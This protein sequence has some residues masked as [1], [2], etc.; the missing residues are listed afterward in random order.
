MRLKTS[1]VDFEII[2]LSFQ[3]VLRL[4]VLRLKFLD[5]DFRLI[6][7]S[8][9]NVYLLLKLFL[10]LL[11]FSL[12]LLRKLLLCLFDSFLFL[13]FHIWLHCL[14]RVVHNC[15]FSFK[16][17]SLAFQLMSVDLIRF[18][19][20]LKSFHLSILS[21]SQLVYHDLELFIS[22][23]LINTKTVNTLNNINFIMIS[24]YKM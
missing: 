24:L 23:L 20:S 6:L 15:L 22:L 13:F 19:L 14:T 3:V 2:L 8:L 7:I 1:F 5:D 11:S 18:I 16:L 10:Y 12:E 21:K 4:C 17:L 9:E